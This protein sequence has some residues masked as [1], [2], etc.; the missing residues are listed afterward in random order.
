MLLAEPFRDIL[1]LAVP[2]SAPGDSGNWLPEAEGIV[3]E[4]GKMRGGLPRVGGE[5][6]GGSA[7]NV[8]LI[9]VG[10]L[11]LLASMMWLS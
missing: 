10:V 7:G 8:W 3:G 6:P 11:A 5:A 1:G 9:L 4:G 2:G